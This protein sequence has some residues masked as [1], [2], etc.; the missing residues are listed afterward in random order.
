MYLDA[1]VDGD[2]S[3]D[4]VA[5]DRVAAVCQFE[6]DALQVLVD[7]EHVVA[8]LHQFLGRI[9]VLEVG[10]TLGS[11]RHVGEIEVVVTLRHISVDHR[12]D[13]QFLLSDV[14]VEVGVLL[15]AHLLDDASHRALV[16][17]Y[18]A[19]L[20]ASLDEFLGVE[21][22]F[23]LRL[24]EGETYLRLRLRGLHDVEPFMAW[25]LVALRENLDLVARV[26]FLSEAHRPA[27]D[28]AA[29]TR[30]ADARVDV[31]GEVEHRRP[32]WE[33]QEVALRREH[34]DLVFLQVGGKLVHQLEVVVVL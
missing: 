11:F 9:L 23:L 8:L 26:E 21:T 4:R 14:L 2:E 20:E 19:V 13:V 30:V 32:L 1:L 31:V 3:E 25:L 7:G 24:L 22:V 12:V 18:L 17:V 34:I 27:I 29:H 6:V 16:D 10:C 28:L 5:I 33:V 15:V